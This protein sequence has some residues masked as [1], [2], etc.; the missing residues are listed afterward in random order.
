MSEVDTIPGIPVSFTNRVQLHWKG[1]RRFDAGRPDGP[2]VRIDASAL[3]GPSPVDAMLIGLAACTSVD[4]VEI[5][6]KRRTPVASLRVDVEAPRAD[7][8]PKRV[9]GVLLTY[10]VAGTGIDRAQAERAID[11]SVNKYCSV[12][13]SLDPDMPVRW[14]LVLEAD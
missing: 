7:A 10:H 8:V 5:L 12:R 13:N 4:V 3:T 9:I 1:D 6:A 11:L 14:K 2:M